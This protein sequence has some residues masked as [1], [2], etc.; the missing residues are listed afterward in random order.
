MFGAGHAVR[1]FPVVAS[2]S[3]C[4][5]AADVVDGDAAPPPRL[6]TLDP[7]SQGAEVL[8]AFRKGAR[9]VVTT[10]ES[11]GGGGRAAANLR[12]ALAIVER[13]VGRAS[14][15][16]AAADGDT[17]THL[18]WFVD[19]CHNGIGFR[20]DIVGLGRTRARMSAINNKPR[21]QPFVGVICLSATA[22]PSD[23]EALQANLGVGSS[24]EVIEVNLNREG[25][26]CAVRQFPLSTGVVDMGFAMAKEAAMLSL[27]PDGGI[28]DDPGRDKSKDRAMIFVLTKGH[29]AQLAKKISA[30][31]VLNACY[32]GA[33]SYD[34]KMSTA[35]QQR[36]LAVWEAGEYRRK[37]GVVAPVRFI[38]STTALAEGFDV[39][40]VTLVIVA[41]PL[42]SVYRT[43]QA[44]GRAGRAANLK[45]L[46]MVGWNIAAAATVS[47]Y[48]KTGRD[49]ALWI[50]ALKFCSVPACRREGLASRLGQSLRRPCSGCDQCTGS[51]PLLAGTGVA[52][53]G[54]VDA[55]TAT[56]ELLRGF[57]PG[58]PTALGVV[59]RKNP[60]KKWCRGPWDA[61]DRALVGTL[62]QMVL[63]NAV[64]AGLLELDVHRDPA[65][66]SSHWTYTLPGAGGELSSPAAAQV[67][68]GK[69]AV[70]I[71]QRT[72]QCT[73]DDDGAWPP[74]GAA[75]Q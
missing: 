60:P 7:D 11:L 18:T 20:K 69:R 25:H 50:D 46:C 70:V 56:R 17:P 39:P 55:T 14:A 2:G 5:G 52:G 26:R 53:R 38:V 36:A 73:P 9:I 51:W 21:D 13:E 6:T 65:H 1:G 72:P 75:Q 37:D 64:A 30:C 32:G 22:L 19:E 44:F 28:G 66:G 71:A 8:A 27:L 68:L 10:A 29:A 54:P 57:E 15:G 74:P 12:L 67:L 59:L 43:Q 33:V 58:E 3:N 16:G 61:T 49:L 47:S 41:L 63:S 35:E 24:A 34:A 45:A 48:M 62:A 31:S 4:D 40:F 23:A 42:G